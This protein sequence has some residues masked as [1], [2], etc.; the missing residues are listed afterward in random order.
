MP[1]PSF[2]LFYWLR[3][4]WSRFPLHAVSQ[5]RKRI[6]QWVNQRAVRSLY[7]P[8][9]IKNVRYGERRAWWLVCLIA[10]PIAFSQHQQANQSNK[11][12]IRDSTPGS[13]I[14]IQ[15]CTVCR[16]SNMRAFYC[17][18]QHQKSQ[19]INQYVP[20]P[21]SVINY[22]NSEMCYERRTGIRKSSGSPPKFFPLFLSRKLASGRKDP[23]K[24]WNKTQSWENTFSYINRTSGETSQ[25]LRVWVRSSRR[26]S[27][28]LHDSF[29]YCPYSRT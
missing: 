7:Q 20:L 9:Q 6:S 23:R 26:A 3:G 29:D 15:K 14:W 5:N 21:W 12:S 13:L 22:L 10:L 4:P 27:W 24:R 1:L 18:P 8:S 28:D 17:V 16:T 25:R 19:S 2:L 11:Q